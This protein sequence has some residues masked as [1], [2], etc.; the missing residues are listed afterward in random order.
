MVCACS[1]QHTDAKL[2]KTLESNLGSSVKELTERY[3]NAARELH[4]AIPVGHSHF[5]SVQ[6]LLH[7]CYWFKAEARFVECWQVLGATV[8]EAQALGMKIHCITHPCMHSNRHPK[9]PTPGSSW[10]HIRVQSGNAETPL[11][12]C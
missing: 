5:F 1:V 8:R 4:S 10:T 7:S 6:Y 12:H 11:V 3:H 2:T 9:R